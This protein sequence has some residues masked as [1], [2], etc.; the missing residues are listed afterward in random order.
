[1]MTM[2]DIKA[3]LDRATAFCNDLFRTRLL[4]RAYQTDDITCDEKYLS[5]LQE[6]CDDFCTALANVINAVRKE[7]E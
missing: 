3:E 6:T 5:R 7:C 2:G 1:M 4:I